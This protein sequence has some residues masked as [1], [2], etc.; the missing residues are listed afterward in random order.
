MRRYLPL[1]S[2]LRSL[3]TNDRIIVLSH[4]D[5]STR[6]AI[7]R[8]IVWV[9]QSTKIPLEHRLLLKK[10]LNPY[11]KE[12][13]NVSAKVSKSMV[14]RGRGGGG[15]NSTYRKT[16][17]KTVQKAD[18]LGQI[19]GKPLTHILDAAIPFLLELFSG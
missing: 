10:R 5:E 12:L 8:T 6:D 7:Y 18:D 15:S 14:G 11:K 1:L 3:D 17:K 13:R 16:S 4:L 9:L 19:G 2:V